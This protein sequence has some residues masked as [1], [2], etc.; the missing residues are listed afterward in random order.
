M[1]RVIYHKIAHNP[2]KSV[3]VSCV[4]VLVMLKDIVQMIFASTAV[5]LV[6]SPSNAGSLEGGNMIAAI[7]AMCWAT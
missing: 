4:E 6:I 7:D 5:S 3:Y 1:K 2:R